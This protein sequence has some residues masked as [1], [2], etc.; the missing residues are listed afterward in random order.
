MGSARGTRT[1]FSLCHAHSVLNWC[2][3][4]EHVRIF[5]DAYKPHPYQEGVGLD[6]SHIVCCNLQQKAEQST[7]SARPPHEGLCIPSSGFNAQLHLGQTCLPAQSADF[8]KIG[9]VLDLGATSEDGQWVHDRAPLHR[10]ATMAMGK[11]KI[12]A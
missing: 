3:G 10:L 4:C 7:A 1:Q 2:I 11:R 9:G 8:I 12:L 5:L 6:T